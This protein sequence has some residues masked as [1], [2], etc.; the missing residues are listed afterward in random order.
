M[1]DFVSEPLD[2][3]FYLVAGRLLNPAPKGDAAFLPYTEKAFGSTDAWRKKT[4]K[5]V[6]KDAYYASSKLK[7]HGGCHF[8]LSP[9]AAS[10][11]TGT[12]L[13]ILNP[14]GF[15]FLS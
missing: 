7:E 4:Q 8:S 2:T 12:D 13:G 6:K 15:C 9:R 10:V 14:K 5:L 11:I 3:H 1:L